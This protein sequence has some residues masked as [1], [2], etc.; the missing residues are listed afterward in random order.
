MPSSK[1]PRGPPGPMSAVGAADVIL[2][3]KDGRLVEQAAT[4]N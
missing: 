4:T 1:L 2:V 3:L